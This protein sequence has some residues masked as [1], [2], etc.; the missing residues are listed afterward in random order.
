[1]TDSAED[2]RRFVRSIQQAVPTIYDEIKVG[3]S[4]Y[5]IPTSDLEILLD[6]GLQGISLAGLPLR[7]RS[8][9]VKEE[10]CKILGYP[11][12]KRFTKT[13]PRF[14]GQ[15]FD[16]Y[17]QN[18]NNLQIWN[19]DVVASRRY[20]IVHVS[21]DLRISRVKVV[22]GR[23]PARLDSTGTLTRKYQA[24]LSTNQNLAELV[25]SEDIEHLKPFVKSAIVLP[26]L[27][28]PS[29][30]PMAGELFSIQALFEK[31]SLLIG[32]SFPDPGPDQERN[33]GTDLHRLV[34]RN[35]GYSAYFDDG[36]FPDILHQML[37]VKLQTSSTI[38]LGLASP[39]SIESLS[40]QGIGAAQSL[41]YCDVRYALFC[42]DTD[43]EYVRLTHLFLTTGEKLFGQFPKFGGKV[44]NKKLQ[45]HLPVDFF[46][47]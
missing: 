19:E 32:K 35:L 28:S 30:T 38:D 41:R 1:M 39:D 23:T 10:I 20:V 36:Q 11:I 37:E 31:L 33:R 27:R 43:G 18:S 13:Q 26:S 24:R 44:Q 47:N 40:I 2:P 21:P 16:V 45:I 12:L 14:L 3:D 7:T 8:R 17:I 29:S 46:M 6:N 22:T 9:F 4:R 5:W 25:C 34:C 42:A 15:L